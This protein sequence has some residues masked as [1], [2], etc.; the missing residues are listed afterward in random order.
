MLRD[1]RFSMIR[2]AVFGTDS[3]RFAAMLGK[4]FC[5]VRPRIRLGV[6]PTCGENNL[7]AT[8]TSQLTI[9]N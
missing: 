5:G 3:F 1:I 8:L 7:I 4:F 2:H 6:F 9:E